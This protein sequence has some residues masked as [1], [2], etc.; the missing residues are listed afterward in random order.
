MSA[1]NPN[2]KNNKEDLDNKKRKVRIEGESTQQDL[3]G[4]L[5]K[6]KMPKLPS[7]LKQSACASNSRPNVVLDLIEIVYVGL[8]VTYL[9]LMVDFY[10]I[11]F[12]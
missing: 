1:S 2:K 12:A 8:E 4:F 10:K 7:A 9:H 6:L 3:I 5:M 11:V